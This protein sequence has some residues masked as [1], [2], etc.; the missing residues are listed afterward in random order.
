MGWGEG[1]PK[2]RDG[3]RVRLRCGRRS[4]ERAAG[5]G[6]LGLVGGPAKLGLCD[7]NTDWG[8]KERVNPWRRAWRKAPEPQPFGSQEGKPRLLAWPEIA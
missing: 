7:G 4:P 2:G 1:W 5:P 3:G 6:P 8:V